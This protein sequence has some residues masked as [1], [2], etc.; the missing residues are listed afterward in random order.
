MRNLLLALV[1][2]LLLLGVF[3][4]LKAALAGPLNGLCTASSLVGRLCPS[5]SWPEDITT[6]KATFKCSW[7]ENSC[8]PITPYPNSGNLKVTITVNGQPGRK[9]EVDTWTSAQPGT[10]KE[11][12]VKYTDKAGVALF[13]GIPA[14]VYYL[15]SNTTSFPK[16]YGNAADSF[17]AQRAEVS[18]G[19]T[20]EIEIK[21]TTK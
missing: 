5:S 16:E 4:G 17:G 21:L 18:A 15:T 20:A 2:I 8:S 14:G 6:S 19:T 10:D 9:I 3:F 13:E 7:V 12:F 11:S 1:V